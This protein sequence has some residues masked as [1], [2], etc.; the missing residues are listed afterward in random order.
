MWQTRSQDGVAERGLGA[1]RMVG[2][3]KVALRNDREVST[4]KKENSCSLV[5]AAYVKVLRQKIAYCA[6]R[7]KE[8]AV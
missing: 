2:K 7:T 3:G 8:Q 4:Q 6:G 5:I 1:R